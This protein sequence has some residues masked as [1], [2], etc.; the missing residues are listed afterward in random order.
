[1]FMLVAK[2]R[3]EYVERISVGSDWGQGEVQNK[4]GRLFLHFSRYFDCVCKLRGYQ[5]S[6]IV[7]LSKNAL[8]FFIL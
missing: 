3:K 5:E 1:M 2:E 6:L 8:V 4:P 7:G